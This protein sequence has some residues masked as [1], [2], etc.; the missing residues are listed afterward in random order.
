MKDVF[1]A[2]ICQVPARR[3]SIVTHILRTPKRV[4]S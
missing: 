2:G 1:I 4:A 3:V